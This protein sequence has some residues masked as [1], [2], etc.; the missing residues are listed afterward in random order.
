MK[1]KKKIALCAFYS[2]LFPFC[3][4]AFIALIM[5]S[6][7]DTLNAWNKNW[8]LISYFI[9]LGVN[10]ISLFMAKILLNFDKR[11]RKKSSSGK[12]NYLAFLLIAPASFMY[13]VVYFNLGI[14]GKL[15]S[16][17]CLALL[18]QF[19]IWFLILAFNEKRTGVSDT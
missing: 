1:N 15:I 12:I 5:D 6:Y 2:I 8:Q 7:N 14:F 19:L 11:L 4:T 18:A 13:R 3:F 10:L 16:H 17:F 9:I